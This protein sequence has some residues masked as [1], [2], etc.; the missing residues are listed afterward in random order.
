MRDLTRSFAGK[1]IVFEVRGLILGLAILGLATAALFL[2]PCGIW[3]QRA[4]A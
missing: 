2:E 1:R 4:V 3:S